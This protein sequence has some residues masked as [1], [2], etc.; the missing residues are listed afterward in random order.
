MRGIYIIGGYPDSAPFKECYR[1]VYEAGFDFI[2]VGIPFNDPVADGPVIAKAQI[3]SVERGITVQSIA[4]DLRELADIPIRTYIMTYAN[5]IYSTGIEN[6]SGMFKDLA[7]GLIIADLPNRMNSFF[8]DR[9]LAIPIIP[10]ATLE[11]RA[12][13]LEASSQAGPDFLYFVGLRGTTGSK[14]DFSSDEMARSLQA[15]KESWNGTVIIGFG[16]KGPEEARQAMAMADGYVIGTEAV[17]RQK[18]PEELR[19]FLSTLS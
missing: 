19:K 15:I 4:R 13:D 10:F 1:A 16:I 14:A 11:S 18:E 7:R 2:E 9:G 3:E 17:K 12:R 6:F 5:I 8:Y